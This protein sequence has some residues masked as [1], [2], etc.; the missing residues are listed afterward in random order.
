M[1]VLLAIGLGALCSWGCGAT[2]S[3]RM[4]ASDR[5]PLQPETLADD[6]VAIAKQVG[7]IVLFVT[8]NGS[9]Q[10]M[11]FFECWKNMMARLPV[12]QH[13]DIMIHEN[14]ANFSTSR[15]RQLLATIPNKLLAIR[16]GF[17][18]G[19]QH[20]ALAPIDEAIRNDWF[21]A[22]D[23]VIKMNPD[24]Y[25]YDERPLL[26]QMQN[27]RTAAVF[28]NCARRCEAPCDLAKVHTDFFAIRPSEL[29]QAAFS[30]FKTAIKAEDFATQVAFKSI[31]QR[32]A[33]SWLVPRGN[34]DTSCRVRG[35][36][37]WHWTWDCGAVESN[38]P[39]TAVQ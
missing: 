12:L 16:H 17:N 22:Y 19:Y 2:L 38:V 27:P 34:N 18:Y 29:S 36:G 37:L 28:A 30:H 25:I 21:W 10:H 32:R 23:W 20:G 39:W 14:A 4:P 31:L 33:E 6:S 15:V 13:A 35:S 7:R 11:T 3:L 26:A 5:A 24:V 9:P 8:T 1:R